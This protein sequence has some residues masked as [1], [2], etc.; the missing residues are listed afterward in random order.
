MVATFLMI[1]LALMPYQMGHQIS[2]A[3]KKEFIKLLQSLPF[4]GEFYTDEAI[5]KAGPYLPVL[6]ALTEKDIK[7]YPIYPFAAVSRGMCD[8]KRHREYAARHFTEIRHPELKLFW[9]AML[10]DAEGGASPEVV[11]FLKDA[12]GSKEQA[13]VLYQIV[14]PDFEGFKRRVVAHPVNE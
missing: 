6:F 7:K 2:D 8:Q 9:A 5:Q 10:F 12:L 1:L 11:Q 3:Q 13:K 4:E 14:G